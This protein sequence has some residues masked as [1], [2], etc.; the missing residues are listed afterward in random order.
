MLPAVASPGFPDQPAYYDDH[1]GERDPEVVDLILPLG[2]PHQLLVGVVPR[3]VG[4]FHHPAQSGRQRSRQALPGYHAHQA[5]TLKKPA[6]LARV[7]GPV[8]V[9]VRLFGKP[10]GG[11]C[12]VER[13]MPR[14]PLST[15][16]VPAFWP[17]HGAFVMHPST[18]T[19]ESSRPMRRS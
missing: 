8:E 1:V 13:L 3:G 2:A 18:D 19:S 7:V 9:D 11:I 4:S 16:L 6:G 17:P 15:G 5:P 12:I 10:D 14:F